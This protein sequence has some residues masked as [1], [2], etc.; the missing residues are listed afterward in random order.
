MEARLREH[1]KALKTELKADNR[2][3][4]DKLDQVLENL[5]AAKP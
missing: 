5:V 3:L 4:G 2:I 1:L